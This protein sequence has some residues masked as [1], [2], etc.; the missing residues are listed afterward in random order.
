[1]DV[2]R[3]IFGWKALFRWDALGA[4]V[5]GVFLAG[6]LAMLSIDW[7]PHHLL[8]SQVCLGI[9]LSLCAVK[10][11]GHAI[12]SNGSIRARIIFAS[13][14]N[15]LMLI[16]GFW[17]IGA[18]QRHK[19]EVLLLAPADSKPPSPV[20]IIQNAD[21]SD[22]SNIAAQ[23]AKIQCQLEREKKRERTKP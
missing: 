5:P 18:I 14:L 3:S 13:C 2:W 6:G 15:L 1:M 7:F 20:V 21:H 19:H 22:C 10:I 17:T 8:I 12:E 4:V 23:E 16:M 9:A 11:I